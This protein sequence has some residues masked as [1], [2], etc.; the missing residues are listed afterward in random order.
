MDP[1]SY[2]IDLTKANPFTVRPLPG[3]P[4]P[5]KTNELLLTDANLR[6]RAKVFPLDEGQLEESKI[7]SSQHLEPGWKW[8]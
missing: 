5:F 1:S 4:P 6:Q 2:R 3:P 8:K 7:I